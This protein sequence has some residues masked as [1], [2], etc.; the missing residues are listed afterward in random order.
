LNHWVACG[1]AAV[2]VVLLT[3]FELLGL[4]LV[5]RARRFLASILAGDLLLLAWYF[6]GRDARLAALLLACAGVAHGFDVVKR[7]N[8]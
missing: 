1:G 7:W 8:F 3:G 6:S 4:V 2:F 5:R